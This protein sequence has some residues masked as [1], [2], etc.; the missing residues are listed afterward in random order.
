MK[1]ER[2]DL[3]NKIVI[4]DDFP[5][6]V[7][8]YEYLKKLE[9]Y[10]EVI[11]YVTKAVDYKEL[12]RRMEG[13]TAIINVR[14]FTSFP[15]K[16]LDCLKNLKIL[17]ILG[18]GTDHVD[19]KAATRNKV[20]VTSTPGASTVSVAEH[21]F[22]LMMA[23]ARHIA[24]GDRKMRK[25]EWYH[26]EGMELGGKVLGIVGLGLIGMHV[27]R[28]AIGFGMRVVGWSRTR[29]EE[30]ARRAGIELLEFDELL[31]LSDFISLHLRLTDRTH[32]IISEREFSLMKPHAVLVNTGR[33]ALVEEN[34]LITA[35][36]ERKIAAAGLDVFEEE[37]V[38][39]DH[40][41]LELE[42]TVLTPHVGWITSDATQRLVR[43]TIDNIINYYEEHPTFVVNTEVLY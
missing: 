4:P 26:C 33:G 27:A 13:A 34:A 20:V 8:G 15:A 9:S 35:L 39:P 2:V 36:R 3:M 10:G 41:F 17:S 7:S 21:S 1:R 16:L 38:S 5:P 28:L 37:P 18:T 24:L 11:P 43:M 42:N 23:C 29:D 30:R 14:A 31:A 40:P 22:A 6:M 25:G 32:S 19:V 12:V